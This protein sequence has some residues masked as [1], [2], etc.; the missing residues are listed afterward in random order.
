MGNYFQGRGEADMGECRMQNV[1]CEMWEYTFAKATVHVDL[2]MRGFWSD[3][4]RVG[5][6]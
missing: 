3:N 6:E 5:P 1:K 2:K 4:G